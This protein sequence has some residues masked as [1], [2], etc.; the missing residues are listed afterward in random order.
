MMLPAN[1]V[2]HQDNL[3][4]LEDVVP[5]TVP[6]KKIKAAASLT[7]ARLRG[8]TAIDDR[9]PTSN[10]QAPTTNGVDVPA[11]TPNHQ[12]SLRMEDRVDDP[13]EQ[14][15]LEMRQA[16]DASRDEDVHMSG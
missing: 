15:E 5:K 10:G 3:E 2:S 16:A 1:A 9:P 14:L 12:N 4:F 8:E 6:L 7:Q 11:L 13:N